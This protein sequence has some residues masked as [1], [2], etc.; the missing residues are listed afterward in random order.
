[1]WTQASRWGSSC[2]VSSAVSSNPGIGLVPQE[3]ITYLNASFPRFLVFWVTLAV[4]TERLSGAD[5]PAMLGEHGWTIDDSSATLTVSLEVVVV[6]IQMR[7]PRTHE[8]IPARARVDAE[9]TSKSPVT[10]SRNRY[11]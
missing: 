3:A 1:M 9:L 4:G 7:R 5:L 10:G 2:F 6:M 11:G 8:V